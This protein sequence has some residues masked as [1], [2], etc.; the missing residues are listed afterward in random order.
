MIKKKKIPDLERKISQVQFFE[1]FLLN[2]TFGFGLEFLQNNIFPNDPMYI[3]ATT[4]VY[5]FSS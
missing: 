4:N 5:C 3:Y 2:L 1:I